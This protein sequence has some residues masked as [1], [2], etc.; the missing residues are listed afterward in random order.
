MAYSFITPDYA[1]KYNHQSV[2]LGQDRSASQH[3]AIKVAIPV[4]IPKNGL[5]VNPSPYP[6]SDPAI[7]APIGGRTSPRGYRSPVLDQQEYLSPQDI[8]PNSYVNF[9][10]KRTQQIE[11][12]TKISP[13]SSQI[14]LDGCQH[15]PCCQRRAKAHARSNSY[16]SLASS[17]NSSS[18]NLS[19]ASPNLSSAAST[20]PRQEQKRTSTFGRTIKFLQRSSSLDAKGGN[21]TASRRRTS[22][23]STKKKQPTKK[24]VFDMVTEDDHWADE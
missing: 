8:S 14:S 1:T 20:S 4:S 21:N 17:A 22:S 9:S 3:P 7:H 15:C 2:N 19:S 23:V 12:N 18:I 6:S 24:I 13:S 11:A 10:R 16:T 5:P